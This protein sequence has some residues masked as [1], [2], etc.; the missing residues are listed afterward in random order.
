MTLISGSLLNVETK[1]TTNFKETVMKIPKF[2]FQKI[3]MKDILDAN[4]TFI[5][6]FF[7][8]LDKYLAGIMQQSV[9]EAASYIGIS[10]SEVWNSFFIYR[11]ILSRSA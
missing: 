5:Q 9:K 1:I 6:V 11:K 8:K 4:S 2:F 7:K 10:L 3:Y